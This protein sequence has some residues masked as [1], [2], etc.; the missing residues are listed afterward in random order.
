MRG[1]FLTPETL[2]NGQR[3]ARLLLIPDDLGFIAAV[4]GALLELTYPWNWEQFGS[5]TP[6]EAAQAASELYERYT[7]G[8]GGVI[9]EVFVWAGD[10]IPPHALLCDGS[11]YNRVDYPDLYSALGT[12]FR[13]DSDHFVTPDIR[14]SGIVGVGQRPGL[15]AYSLGDQGGSEAVTLTADQMPMHGHSEITAVATLINGGLEAPAAAA[16][17]GVGTTGTAGLSQSHE[18]RPPYLALRYCIWAT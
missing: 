15:S 7:K 16:V 2:G 17:P 10:E 13:L 4:S 8:L 3:I 5:I 6:D 14:S 1:R 18:N 9:G 12:C 11:Q